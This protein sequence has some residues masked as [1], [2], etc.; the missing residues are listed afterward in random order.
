M[1]TADAAAGAAATT[2]H[3]SPSAHAAYSPY[4]PDSPQRYA[5]PYVDNGAGQQQAWEYAAVDA[6]AAAGHAIPTAPLP[7]A[8]PAAAFHRHATA[9]SAA[10][11]KAKKHRKDEIHFADLRFGGKIGEGSFGEVFRGSLWGQEVAIKKLR[12]QAVDGAAVS[13]EFK[14]EV[15][16]MRTLRHPNIVEFLGVCMEPPNLCL[17]TEY[18]SNGIARGRTHSHSR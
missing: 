1:R 3:A 6:F 16:I 15:K 4:M 5:H 10:S 8:H 18:L 7:S 14:K 11:K 9:P 17:V 2:V 12:I 13:K